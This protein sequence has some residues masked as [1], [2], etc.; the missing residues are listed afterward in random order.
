MFFSA[1]S[2]KRIDRRSLI[3]GGLLHD[4]FL[5]DWHIYSKKHEWHGFTHAGCA[6]SNSN[7]DFKLN[8]IEQDI[9]KKH[10]FP[11]NILPPAYLESAIVCMADKW[12]AM[13][14]TF[15]IALSLKH[16]VCIKKWNYGIY[17]EISN[18]SKQCFLIY[19]DG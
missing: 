5:Y 3:R 12:C 6:L 17:H 7:R 15:H 8:G 10:M 19:N 2:K 1:F 18:R 16:D 4:Y 13:C 14:E 11:L 9:I